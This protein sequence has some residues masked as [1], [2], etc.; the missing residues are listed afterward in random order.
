MDT[1]GSFESMVISAL[2]IATGYGGGFWRMALFVC[3]RDEDMTL[4]A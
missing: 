4:R 3:L 2:R 1:F